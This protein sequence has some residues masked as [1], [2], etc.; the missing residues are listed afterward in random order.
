MND[1]LESDL[2]DYAPLVER[3]DKMNGHIPSQG[4]Q[5]VSH[6]H[7]GLI[8]QH[9]PPNVEDLHYMLMEVWMPAP[10]I[11]VCMVVEVVASAVRS[12]K[13]SSTAT[14]CKHSVGRTALGREGT[15]GSAF[16]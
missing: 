7:N 11:D 3:Y 2:F 16:I 4:T 12:T 5:S 1:S 15:E 8:G 6:S 10:P 13:K 14:R 9:A